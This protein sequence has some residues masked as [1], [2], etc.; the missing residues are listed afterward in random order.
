MFFFSLWQWE[1][2]STPILDSGLEFTKKQ[3]QAMN[4]LVLK[5]KPPDC[6]PIMTLCLTLNILYSSYYHWATGTSYNLSS[7]W[8]NLY[9]QAASVSSFLVSYLLII[10]HRFITSLTLSKRFSKMSSCINNLLTLNHGF[11]RR[12]PCHLTK[13]LQRE[14]ELY[15][16]FVTPPLV[17][18][19]Y[20]HGQYA[21]LNPSK[22]VRISRTKDWTWNHLEHLH[23]SPSWS[24]LSKSSQSGL[25]FFR[26]STS[27]T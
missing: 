23:F 25:F 13:K 21:I 18:D 11:F 5:H 1:N 4:C 26:I 15:F 20:K 6:Y 17:A 8:T 19:D 22:F 16:L 14:G 12:F 27:K 10:F 9:L 2:K 24:I 3:V 7:Y